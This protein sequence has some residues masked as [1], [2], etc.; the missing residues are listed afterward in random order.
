[1]KKKKYSSFYREFKEMHAMRKKIDAKC[2]Q[3]NKLMAE[4]GK[5]EKEKVK[6]LKKF[7]GKRVEI[8]WDDDSQWKG[9]IECTLV[10]IFED[11]NFGWGCKIEQKSIK[12]IRGPE[13]KILFVNEITKI[14]K[15]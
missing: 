9:K 2:K 14:E 7:V 8:C 6:K 4:K 3:I 13:T 5:L 11:R 1:M 12:Y 10:K 15:V